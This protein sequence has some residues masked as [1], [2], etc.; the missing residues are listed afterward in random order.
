MLEDNSDMEKKTPAKQ[1]NN[2]MK[3]HQQRNT[4]HVTQIHHEQ[5]GE[6][7]PAQ[8]KHKQMHL[9]TACR[10]NHAFSSTT[11]VLVMFS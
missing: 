11:R 4:M 3:Q 8:A 2:T 5:L 6:L 10:Q 7:H 9:R 1:Q